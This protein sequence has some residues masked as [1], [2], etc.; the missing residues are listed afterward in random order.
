M[1][2]IGSTERTYGDEGDDIQLERKEG[3]G[4][5]QWEGVGRLTMTP[6]SVNNSFHGVMN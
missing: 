2:G 4:G 3:R 1:G 5:G 6:S